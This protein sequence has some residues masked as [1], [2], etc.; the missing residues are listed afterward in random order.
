MNRRGALRDVLA[1][2]HVVQE[3]S[4]ASERAERGPSHMEPGARSHT[5]FRAI[6]YAGNV[7]LILAIL[8]AG[9]AA[10]W[11]YSTRRYLKGFSDAVVPF[12]SSPE[13]KV[14]AILHWMSNG[15]SR[16]AGPQA[17]GPDRNPIDT[18]NYASLLKVCGTATNAFVN[19]GDS[20]G[21]AVRRLLLLDSHHLT[22]HA[23]AE[24]LIDGRW[25]VV[26]PAFRRV[27]RG[28]DGSLLTREQ[29]SSP[30]VFAAAIR[31]IHGYDPVGNYERTV[32][33]RMARLG[34]IG[35]PLR[36]ALNLLLPGW[37]DSTAISLLMERESLATMVAALVLAFLLGLLRVGLRWYGERRLGVRPVRIRQQ[38]RRALYAFVD[39]G[40]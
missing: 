35:Q 5:F 20:A 10:V 16:A 14:E 34:V 19:L 2:A 23:V 17:L 36:R 33:V 37:E 8:L 32:H 4:P 11:E 22:M 27:M 9:Y 30:A 3:T 13:E 6:W 39:T 40:G 18:L 31:S 12:A 26:D 29:L 24:V 7:L 21:L 25:I 28:T 15:P 1:D 38:I